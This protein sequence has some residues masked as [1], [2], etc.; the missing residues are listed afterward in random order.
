MSTGLFDVLALQ[1]I[2]LPHTN[3]SSEIT[4]GFEVKTNRDTAYIH[5]TES[6]FTTDA[7]LSFAINTYS[8]TVTAAQAKTLQGVTAGETVTIYCEMYADDLDGSRS[9]GLQIEF[10][11]EIGEK[12]GET[13]EIEITTA[14]EWENFAQAIVVPT[15]ATRVNLY[16][17]AGCG[18]GETVQ[19]WIAHLKIVRAI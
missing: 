18:A 16:V 5:I 13:T 10:F 2:A 1:G 11:N 14:A 7:Y 3:N 8:K 4:A 6:T 17:H 12:Q 15:G 9:A 19:V